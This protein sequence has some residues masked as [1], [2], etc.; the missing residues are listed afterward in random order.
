MTAASL[1]ARI[2]Y[3]VVALPLGGAAG[4]YACMLALPEF[5]ASHPHI[6]PH[7][8]G[9]GI[10]KIA[11]CVGAAVAFSAGLFAL[12]LP[13]IRHRK[14]PGRAWRIGLSCALVVLASV[15]IADEGFGLVVDLVIAGWLTYTMAFTFVRYGV[16]DQAR[17]KHTSVP[18]Y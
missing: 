7:G 15:A 1:P 8:D 10:F 11:I 4:F 14:R 13:W 12:T 18:D 16:I 3:T 5:T 17:R 2:A 9:S 6:D